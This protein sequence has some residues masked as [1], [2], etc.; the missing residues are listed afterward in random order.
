VARCA[1]AGRTV[2]AAAIWA[3]RCSICSSSGS[4]SLCLELSSFQLDTR[5][6][7][8]PGCGVLNVTAIIWMLSVGG[9]VRAG[10]VGFSTGG[11]VVLNADDP[12]VAA[13]RGAVNRAGSTQTV[14]FSI[15]RPDA[16]FSL[17]RTGTQTLLARH[18]EGLLDVSR[19]KITGC[20]TPPMRLAALAGRC[21]GIAVAPCWARSRPFRPVAPPEWVADWRGALRR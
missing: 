12:R 18:G 2:L 10:Q 8:A 7:A 5:I 21:G 19:M 13:M 17:L 15:E 1:A 4:G 16:D 3:N 6:V 20:T 11:T 9:G 14:T